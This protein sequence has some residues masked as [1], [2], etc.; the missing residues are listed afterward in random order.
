[1]EYFSTC[2]IYENPTANIIFNGERPKA[3]PLQS[4]TRK[5]CT[6]LPLLFN[7]ILDVL[8][9]TLRQGN[10]I[11]RIQIGEETKV[12]IFTD[13]QSYIKKILKQNQLRIAI[14]CKVNTRKSI[15]SRCTM[16]NPNKFFFKKLFYNSIK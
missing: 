12:F 9:R 3:F 11:K 6:L 10:Q 5:R 16:S 15:L 4:K 13:P 1:M 2:S 7:I 14:V 8:A